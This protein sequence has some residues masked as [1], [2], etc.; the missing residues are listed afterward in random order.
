M[1]TQAKLVTYDDYQNLPD[2]GNRYEII[3]GEL[4]MAPSPN[5]NHQKISANLFY[6]LRGYI[7]KN[8]LGEIFYA[9][10]DV[11]LSMTDVVEPDLLFIGKERNEIIAEKNIV[12]A[13]DLVVEILSGSTQE[14]DRNDKKDLY[15]KHKV[16]EYW[17]VNPEKRQVEQY[18]LSDEWYEQKGIFNESDSFASKIIT[19]LEI[20]LKEVFSV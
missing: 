13:P 5:T 4:F 19:G 12:A 10:M 18:V 17:I 9:P 2:D 1:A 16:K 6:M 11:V 7:E 3:R 8:N 20:Q 15:E 14:K